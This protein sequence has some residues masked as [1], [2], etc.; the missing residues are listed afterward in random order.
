MIA[1]TGSFLFGG[2]GFG[3]D[4]SNPKT[5]VGLGVSKTS[6][7]LVGL[8]VG[9]FV[10]MGVGLLVGIGVELDATCAGWVGT[11]VGKFI[12]MGWASESE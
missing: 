9:V 5:E 11:G 7:V 12:C 3:T 6:G 8:I 1:K 4:V 2:S 10:G